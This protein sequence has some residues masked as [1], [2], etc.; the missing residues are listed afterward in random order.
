MQSLFHKVYCCLSGS[1]CFLCIRCLTGKHLISAGIKEGYRKAEEIVAEIK[2]ALKT[3][4]DELEWIDD[5][6]R[7]DFKRKVSDIKVKLGYPEDI[8]NS[9]QIDQEYAD[10]NISEDEFFQNVVNSLKASR[11]QHFQL[12]MR[13]PS[14]QSKWKV[15]PES[16]TAYYS[17]QHH[18]IVVPAGLFQLPFFHT[19]A[20]RA[21][22]FG[23]IGV[24]MAHEILHAFYE[25]VDTGN[26]CHDCETMPVREKIECMIT[27][28]NQYTLQG[29]AVNGSLTLQENMADCGGLEIAFKAYENWLKK[30]R[31]ETV[32]P[33]SS[34]T[35][36][37][38]FFTSY[39][40]VM[41]GSQNNITLPEFLM[42]SP[43]SPAR[44][45]VIG[46]LSNSKGFSH[47][48]YC[49]EE[50]MMNPLKK[51]HIW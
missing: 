5:R 43:H 36:H 26:M 21:L 27:Q 2:L 33:Q 47:H 3:R 17:L 13:D 51:C 23:G 42:K 45:R 18:E 7:R 25:Y 29:V 11:T 34:L 32:L 46:P 48:F 31:V 50:S 6:T 4:I 41:C 1:P 24:I 22:N 30:D 37:Q 44:Y 38:L 12:G 35:Q 49:L 39:A 28:Y 20:P 40:Q 8:M 19:D 14:L 15:G 9:D 10:Y 16:V